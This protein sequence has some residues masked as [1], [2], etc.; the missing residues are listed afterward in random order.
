MS[1]NILIE[2]IEKLITENNKKISMLEEKM[3]NDDY[4]DMCSPKQEIARL[5]K[6][7][8]EEQQQK[9]EQHRQ[10]ILRLER[11]RLAEINRHNSR[12]EAQEDSRQFQ[13]SLDNLN[14]QIRDMTPKTY[15]VNVFHY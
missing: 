10:D 11:E 7:R 9:E 6:Q 3:D 12:I 15:N 5:E 1:E 13:Q 2:E 14:K 8:Y 4:K